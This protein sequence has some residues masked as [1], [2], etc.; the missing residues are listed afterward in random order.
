MPNIKD[1]LSE[2]NTEL[3]SALESVFKCKDYMPNNTPLI[4]DKLWLPQKKDLV[5]LSYNSFNKCLPNSMPFSRLLIPNKLNQLNNQY[6]YTIKPFT[7]LSEQLSNS[8]QG[9]MVYTRK[10]RIF[11]TEKQKQFF[12]QCFGANRF[13]YNECIAYDQRIRQKDKLNTFKL[14]LLRQTGCVFLKDR[15]N[16]CCKK[17]QKDYRVSLA[18]MD[19]L[20]QPKYYFCPEHKKTKIERG[21]RLNLQDLRP[22]IIKSKLEEHE[23]WQNEIPY[24]TKQLA[25][26]EF[27]GSKKSGIANM[28]NGNIKYFDMKFKS[29]KNPRQM[30]H[31]DHRAVKIEKYICKSKTKNK[32]RMRTKMKRWWSK[33]ITSNLVH[34]CILS[35]DGTGKYYLCLLLDKKTEEYEPENEIVSI[36]PGVRTFLTTYS[37]S[38]QVCKIGDN[39]CDVL[40]K[41]AERIDKLQSLIS[42]QMLR[43]TR[44]NMKKRCSNLR[45]KIKNIVE[46]LH[47]K[48]A[49][50]LC[51]NNKIIL[52]PEFGSRNMTR[53]LPQKARI[54]N[55]KTVRNMLSLSHYKFQQRLKFKAQE[56]NRL[57]LTC[58]E[59]YTT[60]T[61]GRCGTINNNVGSKKI[62]NCEL[63][64]LEID[65]DVN[66]ARNI[67][68]K[69]ISRMGEIRPI[70]MSYD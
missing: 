18:E 68:I 41:K 34:D 37:P 43:R 22:E 3:I 60:K 47:K 33:N 28:K 42:T 35:K 15:D 29:K 7:Q 67:L 61:C 55:S 39:I 62:F 36:D 23:L 49:T 20:L 4:S 27:I 11:P 63:C 46:D 30:F 44:Y 32:I 25:I 69:H 2:M 58:E 64:K 17:L 40:I 10:I 48:A 8:S 14:N 16:Q 51:K 70:R 38:G 19:S 57:V 65:R 21:Y 12:S 54:I 66:G 1:A 6:K 24:D 52:L 59:S 26:K 5:N 9:N 50:Y 56:Y 45:T 53:K 31:L 13:F